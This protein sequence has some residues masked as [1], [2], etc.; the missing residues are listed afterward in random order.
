MSR[1]K[2]VTYEERVAKVEEVLKNI[3]DIE[4]YHR[5]L[6]LK[7]ITPY[8]F[9]NLDHTYDSIIKLYE[10]VKDLM[11]EEREVKKTCEGHCRSA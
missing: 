7:V 8:E 6:L 5:K 3:L 10:L 1:G 4:R 9:G 2:R 11:V